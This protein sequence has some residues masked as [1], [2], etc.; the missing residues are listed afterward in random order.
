VTVVVR[1]QGLGIPVE[2]RGRIFERFFQAHDDAY[3]SGMGLGLYVSRQ[4]VE[5]HRGQ[6]RAEFP[7]DGGTRVV[8]ELPLSLSR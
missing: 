3:A 4:I 6:I 2:K 8:V 5:L 1:D 7:A